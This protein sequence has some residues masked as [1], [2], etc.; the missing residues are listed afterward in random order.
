MA[1]VSLRL[2]V[3]K[4]RQVDRL[5]A[6]YQALGLELAEERHGSEP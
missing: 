3:L 4:T 2:L 1:N 6:F 5:R